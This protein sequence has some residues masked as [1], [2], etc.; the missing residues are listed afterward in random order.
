MH[1]AIEG[2]SFVKTLAIIYATDPPLL[3]MNVLEGIG[4]RPEKKIINL[5]AIVGP[6]L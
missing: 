5:V 4:R 2:L 1:L 6:W 3:K